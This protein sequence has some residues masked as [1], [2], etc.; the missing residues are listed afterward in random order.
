MQFLRDAATQGAQRT[1]ARCTI[2]SSVSCVCDTVKV[3]AVRNAD[4]AIFHQTLWLA[5]LSAIATDAATAVA[6]AD[7]L[8]NSDI[9]AKEMEIGTVPF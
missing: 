8:C 1:S 3:C 7:R 5:P 4:D 9:G 2:D 6:A